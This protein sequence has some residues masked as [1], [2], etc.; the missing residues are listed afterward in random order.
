MSRRTMSPLKARQ[1]QE[2]NSPDSKIHVILQENKNSRV[3]GDGS[4]NREAERALVG[5]RSKL[6]TNLS[7]ECHVN[8]LIQVATN[9]QNLARMYAGIE[10]HS[11]VAVNVSSS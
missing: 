10:F 5:V 3:D 2:R 9:S 4:S 8:D 7:V 11:S 6:S 1:V